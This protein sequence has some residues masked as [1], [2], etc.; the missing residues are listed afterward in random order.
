MN[1]EAI[2]K[3]TSSGLGDALNVG[4]QGEGENI[5]ADPQVSSL[6]PGGR[7]NCLERE[8]LS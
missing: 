8:R 2:L 6:V 3:L 7:K 1:L 5:G 4:A